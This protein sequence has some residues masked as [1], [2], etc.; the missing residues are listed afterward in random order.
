MKSLLAL[1]LLVANF[2]LDEII[3]DI[4]NTATELTNVE[5]EQLQTDLYALHETPIDLNHATQEE[6]EQLVFLTPRQ[7]DDIMMYIMR[8]P[9]D[10][11]YELQL[12]PSLESYDIR[13]MLPFVTISHDRSGISENNKMYAR[14]VF[15][16][17]KHEIVTR[18]DA[19]N[20]EDF[21]GTDPM[22]AQLRYRFDFQRRVTFG[23]QIRRPAGGGAKDLEYGAYLQLKDIGHLHTLVAGNFQASF[24]HGLV[25]ASPFHSG[26]SMYISAV[27]QKKEGLKYYSSVDG[28]GLHGAGATMRWN[29]GPATRLDVSALYSMKRANDSTWQHVIGANLTLRHKQLQVELTAAEN[30]WSD[31]IRPYR[32]AAYNMHY[33]RGFRQFVGGASARYNFGLAELFGE[34]ATSENY[35]RAAINGEASNSEAINSPHWG[36]GTLVGSRIYP[37]KGVTLVALYR[38][39]SPYFDNALGYGFSETSRLGDENGGYVGIDI[40]G[41]N[42]WRFSGYAD[43]FYFSGPKYGI[44]QSG[45]IGYDAVAEVGFRNDLRFKIYD[46]KFRLRARK[47]GDLSTYSARGQFNWSQGGWS[48]RTTAEANMTREDG[49]PVTGYGVTVFQDIGYTFSSIPLALRGR[50][51]FFDAREWNNRIYTY[52]HDVLYAFSIPATYGLGGRIYACL[53]WQI[54]PQLALYLRVSETIYERKWSAAHKKEPTRTDVHLLLRATL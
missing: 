19:R 32:D 24:G 45:T 1:I 37:T 50:A 42:K 44:P 4:Y 28:G 17:A 34:V 53:K 20:I 35:K 36:V 51:Q 29:W 23:A 11:L 52:E 25:F 12:I 18:V 31:S 26:K 3:Y 2:S 7:V 46:F 54:I 39:Y 49:L 41:L 48:L 15:A 5:Y 13:N 27:G 33:F 47:K 21:E 9:M 30:L 38:Y 22:Y 16:Y 6:L 8:H 43:V 14:E 10:S 40:S